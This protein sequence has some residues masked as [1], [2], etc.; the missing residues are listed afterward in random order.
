MNAAP[1]LA[2]PRGIA[3]AGRWSSVIHDPNRRPGA[4]T[5]RRTPGVRRRTAVVGRAGRPLRIWSFRRR[6]D[7]RRV[8]VALGRP[9]W[10]DIAGWAG[11]QPR[12]GSLRRTPDVRRRNVA[13]GRPPGTDIAG[14]AGRHLR[15][16]SL[17]RRPDV[18]SRIVALG[19]PPLTG[20][21]PTPDVL[22][23]TASGSAGRRLRRG[24]GRRPA[25]TTKRVPRR[26]HPHDSVGAGRRPTGTAQPGRHPAPRPRPGSVR[27]G[28][29]GHCRPARVRCQLPTPSRPARGPRR[30]LRSGPHGPEG[31]AS[32]QEGPTGH[33]RRPGP[34]GRR[35]RH[36]PPG[37][38]HLGPVEGP[39]PQWVDR[40]TAGRHP[41]HQH[42]DRLRDGEAVCPLLGMGRR[43]RRRDWDDGK[44]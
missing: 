24:S 34:A 37:A 40:A 39:V 15:I 38:A 23:W 1:R 14:R 30:T 6:P 27:V 21:C 3:R 35:R 8:N 5:C 18:R 41:R 31:A 25:P 16:G 4:G 26:E 13:L 11:R 10:T 42:G 36:Q 29:G 43:C 20:T 9:P 33:P 2:R 44:P 7:V 17:R 19:R 22:R 28:P 12:I 32:D